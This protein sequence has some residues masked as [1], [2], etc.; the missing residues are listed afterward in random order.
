MLIDGADPPQTMAN[1]A[2]DIAYKGLKG[3]LD[4]LDRVGYAV[5]PLKAAASGLSRVM[6][7][8]DVGIAASQWMTMQ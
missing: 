1:A 5:P 7:V 6:T 2:R 8:I 4:V 3:L